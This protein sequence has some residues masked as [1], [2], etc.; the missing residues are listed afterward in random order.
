MTQSIPITHDDYLSVCDFYD[1]TIIVKTLLTRNMSKTAD[2][3]EEF[4]GEEL[5]D[6]LAVQTWLHFPHVESTVAHPKYRYFHLM[7][8]SSWN[9]IG[10]TEKLTIKDLDKIRKRV[11]EYMKTVVLTQSEYEYLK[12]SW[13][14][15]LK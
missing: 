6:F 12:S 7:P 8:P 1:D 9:W 15:I 3:M 5:S 14:F 10:F 2:V 13:S 4:Y 11:L